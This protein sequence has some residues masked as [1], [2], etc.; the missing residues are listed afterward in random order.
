MRRALQL[1]NAAT[2]LRESP[3]SLIIFSGPLQSVS[4]LLPLSTSLSQ[5]GFHVFTC[6]L[7][8]PHFALCTSTVDEIVDKIHA[9]VQE[10][11][12]CSPPVALTF[13]LESIL[14]QKY[15]E[16]YPLA[17]LVM[18]DPLPPSPQ[19]ALHGLLRSTGSAQ[20][21]PKSAACDTAQ[22]ATAALAA[23]LAPAARTPVAATMAASLLLRL[24]KEPVNLE[25]SPVPLL[26]LGDELQ[27]PG[28]AATAAL[29]GI[30]L[31]VQPYSS[32]AIQAWVEQ[33]Y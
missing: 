31:P 17:G 26:L 14:L 24:A 7:L 10:A 8:R 29:H 21:L 12:I 30:Q 23:A 5:R 25:P 11:R 18:V 16:S 15:L 28:V 4:P 3:T 32:Q 2:G 20:R 1:L 19:Q 22:P 33:R 13:G 27:G 9:S 6:D